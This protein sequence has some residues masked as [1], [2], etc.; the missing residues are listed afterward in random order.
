[1]FIPV[2][3]LLACFALG[4]GLVLAVLNIRYRDVAYLTGI[5]LQIWFY[6]TPIV[7][8]LDA[9][10]PARGSGSSSTR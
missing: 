4:V 3:A 10:P 6:A 2:F 7:Y 8:S 5:L 9:I 1:M